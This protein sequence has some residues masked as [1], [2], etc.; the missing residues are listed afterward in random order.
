MFEETMMRHLGLPVVE[1]QGDQ[2]D[3]DF[4]SDLRTNYAIDAVLEAI[5]SGKR[6]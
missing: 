3:T 5:A 1:F 2:S 4:Y 6:R